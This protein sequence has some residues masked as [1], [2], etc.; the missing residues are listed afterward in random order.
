MTFLITLIIIAMVF[1]FIGEIVDLISDL[2][3]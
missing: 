3:R 1:S 2:I